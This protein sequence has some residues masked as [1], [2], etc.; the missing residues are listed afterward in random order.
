MGGGQLPAENN[1]ATLAVPGNP[2]GT[3]SR[4]AISGPSAAAFWA[5]GI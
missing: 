5:G 3:A 4:R 1:P 2:R